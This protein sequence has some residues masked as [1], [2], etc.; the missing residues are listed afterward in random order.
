MLHS[1][2]FLLRTS[3]IQICKILRPASLIQPFFFLWTKKHSKVSWFGFTSDYRLSSK[4]KCR[5]IKLLKEN[6][7]QTH[8]G[9]ACCRVATLL[10]ALFAR[11][12][13]GRWSIAIG[14]LLEQGITVNFNWM[15]KP[16]DPGAQGGREEDRGYCGFKVW[17]WNALR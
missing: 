15:C 13:G 1:R 6:L 10:T 17:S 11:Q 9:N 4:S 12:Q 8:W 5:R 14:S 7:H 3:L 16:S 2:K